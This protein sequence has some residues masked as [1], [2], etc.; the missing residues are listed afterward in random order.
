MSLSIGG[1]NPGLLM[2]TAS[3]LGHLG[4]VLRSRVETVRIAPHGQ[5]RR[6]LQPVAGHVLSDVGEVAGLGESPTGSRP[7]SST[8][9][10]RLAGGRS[11][12]PTRAASIA[13]RRRRAAMPA[14]SGRQSVL[15]APHLSICA[16]A[17]E[18]SPVL[19]HHRRPLVSIAPARVNCWKARDSVSGTVPTA[20]AS[21][22][23]E[24]S[25]STVCSS[26]APGRQREQIAPPAAR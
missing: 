14:T 24:I 11:R 3:A 17:L 25:S 4:G 15:V 13:E 6:D 18:Q 9:P 21:S 2:I 8:E 12:R 20:A 10:A 5:Q 16:S 19:D 23:F 1:S 7:R 22:P 26:G